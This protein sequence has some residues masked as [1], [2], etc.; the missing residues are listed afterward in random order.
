[1]ERAGRKRA[2][3]RKNGEDRAGVNEMMEYV[4]LFC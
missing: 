1:M 3:G 2:R 4:A